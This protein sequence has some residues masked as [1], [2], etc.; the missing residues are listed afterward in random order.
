ML[1]LFVAEVPTIKV[2]NFSVVEPKFLLFLYGIK[3]SSNHCFAV[4]I[5]HQLLQQGINPVGHL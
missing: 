4:Q 2:N 3:H 5:A 1:D